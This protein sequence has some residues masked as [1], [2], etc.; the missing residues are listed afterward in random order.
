VQWVARQGVGNLQQRGTGKRTLQVQLEQAVQIGKRES[1]EFDDGQPIAMERA[2][3]C[4]ALSAGASDAG[5]HSHGFDVQSA[6]SEGQNV[7][8]RGVQPLGVVGR[9]QQWSLASHLL[10]ERHERHAHDTFVRGVVVCNSKQDY[11][12]CGALWIGQACQPIG[13]DVV[14][15]V[16]QSR[17]PETQLG[18]R[19]TAG[20]HANASASGRIDRGVPDRRLA[21]PRLAF[22][23]QTSKPALELTQ[24]LVDLPQLGLPPD[25]PCGRHPF[26]HHKTSTSVADAFAF[27]G[28]GI[29]ARV[30]MYAGPIPLRVDW[31]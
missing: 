6:E 28:H 7:R 4:G 20:K 22:E 15:Q 27:P 29:I 2:M 3:E 19:R 5:E 9:Q 11:L 14:Q 8:G 16:A 31:W 12:E 26:V 18:L 1:L 10:D 17:E 23:G 13:S 21:Y 24:E 30:A 25:E